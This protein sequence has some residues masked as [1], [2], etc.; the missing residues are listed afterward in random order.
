MTILKDNSTFDPGKA[1]QHAWERY[2]DAAMADATPK[3]MQKAVDTAQSPYRLTRAQQDI[4]D[5]HRGV[6]RRMRRRE[7]IAGYLQAVEDSTKPTIC[8]APLEWDG[9][10]YACEKPSTHITEHGNYGH[11]QGSVTWAQGVTSV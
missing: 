7:F 10:T 5:V 11:E 2:R 9:E 6:Q 4:Q 1:A 3:W 8:R